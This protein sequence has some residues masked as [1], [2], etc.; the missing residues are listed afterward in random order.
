MSSDFIVPRGTFAHLIFTDIMDQQGMS[1]GDQGQKDHEDVG[2]IKGKMVTEANKI[3]D[4]LQMV[5]REDPEMQVYNDET[6][7]HLAE[8]YR[9]LMFNVIWDLTRKGTGC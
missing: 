1:S 3:E 6:R 9:Y 4:A 2:A 5:I 8:G 7:K